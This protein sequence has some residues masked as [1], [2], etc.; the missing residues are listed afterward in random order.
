MK[1]LRTCRITLTWPFSASS[2]TRCSSVWVM[3]HLFWFE[4]NHNQTEDGCV[5]GLIPWAPEESGGDLG[6]VTYLHIILGPPWIRLLLFL[7]KQKWTGHYSQNH[8]QELPL[9]V[10]KVSTTVIWEWVW[11]HFW[12]GLHDIL[13]AIV[14]RISSVKTVLWLAVCVLNA[15]PFENSWWRI[16]EPSLL[17]RCAWLS[18]AKYHAALLL[19]VPFFWLI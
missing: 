16:T 7:W 15:A 4:T 1:T 5:L 14:L 8:T 6:G 12:L 10:Y 3:L 2:N 9:Q 18:H 13:H 11:I 19:T 17:T